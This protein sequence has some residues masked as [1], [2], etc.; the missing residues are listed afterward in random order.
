MLQASDVPAIG[1][2]ALAQL[3][4]RTE[5]WAAGLRL[6]ALSLTG[7]ANPGAVLERL[8]GTHRDIADYFCEEVLDR[9]DP[10]LVQFLVETSTLDTVSAPLAAAV[11]GTDAGD[12]RFAQAVTSGVFMIPLDDE[13][14]W[15]RYHALFRDLLHTRLMAI[16]VERRNE[17]ALRA[18]AWYE[19]HG[20]VHDSMRQALA[21]GDIDRI[22]ALVERHADDLMYETG[23]AAFLVDVI[24]ELPRDLVAGRPALLRVH[25]WAL[26]MTGRIDQ[27]ERLLRRGC[28]VCQDLDEAHLLAVQARLAAYR[29]DN[30]ATVTFGRK[31]LDHF[32]VLTDGRL[33]ADVT[34]SM[35]FAERAMGHV[36]NAAETFREAARLGRQHRN[37]QAA[38]WGVRYLALARI[39][40]GRL[41]EALAIVDEDLDRLDISNGD[42]GSH[43]AAL[44]VTRAEILTARNQLDD[45]HA[46][47]DP[48]FAMIQRASDAKMLM[49]AYVA[50]A[51]LAQAEGDLATARDKARRAEELFPPVIPGTWTA[52]IALAQGDLA[53]AE[54]W[55]TSTGYSV[56]DEPDPTRGE[57][58]QALHARILA[59]LD[60][61]GSIDLLDRFAR[62]AK[63]ADRLGQSIAL[64]VS[65]A[66][67]LARAGKQVAADQVLCSAIVD[68]SRDGHIQVFLDEGPPMRAKL[69]EALRSRDA[70][71]DECRA[72]ALD[73]L[74]RFPVAGSQE[75]PVAAPGLADP[76]TARQLEI[77]HLLADGRSNR[78]IADALFIAEGTVKAH[79]HQ[80]FGKLVARNRTEAVANA[81]EHSLIP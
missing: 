47:L 74:G 34:L 6:V 62:S 7:S 8:R 2:N 9:L 44:L 42:G 70:L 53:T 17:L 20:L 68:A 51:I 24:E 35:G 73:L 27:A 25:A 67:A 28:E 36:D 3:V 16:P 72:F 13:R 63:Q 23:D 39:A 5:G 49:N 55:A 50:R 14:T 38:R 65:Q 30:R 57:F 78:E 19:D 31:A 66:M 1:D 22:A 41:G 11:I 46:A 60:K 10:G 48:A 21:A 75:G 81:R 32:D 4:A 37:G 77:L 45:A 33:I 56:H 15:Y 59:A 58:E 54:R 43:R 18:S 26:T 12:D 76:L 64:R 61:P 29:G 71:S 69:R 79:M 40:Q 80:L 52:T